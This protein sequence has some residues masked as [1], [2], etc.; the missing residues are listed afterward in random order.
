MD[1][2][3]KKLKSEAQIA[4]AR[5]QDRTLEAALAVEQGIILHG[6]T[7]IW[8]CFNG[9]RFSF[10]LN[11]Y[12]SEGQLKRLSNSL[13]W[14]LD[15]RGI[16]MDYSRFTERVIDVHDASA[17][18]KLEI[19]PKPKGV[20]GVQKEYIKSDG[21]KMFINTLSEDD[22]IMEKIKAYKSRN[23]ARDI[24][25]IYY[26]VLSSTAF[27]TKIRRVLRSF[28][29]NASPPKDEDQLRELV[30]EG[31]APRFSTMKEYIEKALV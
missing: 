24:Y 18:T 31:V 30:Y 28:I 26:L 20:H 10:D 9:R 8:R 1:P 11:I 25:D 7:A 29:K 27:D 23:Y 15:K 6:G 22:F 12:A 5:L 3:E 13:T 2:I 17:S 16:I 4:I 14:E 21:T 19:S